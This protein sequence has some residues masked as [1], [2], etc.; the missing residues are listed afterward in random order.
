[1]GSRQLHPACPF[2]LSIRAFLKT[3]FAASCETPV[4]KLHWPLPPR[5]KLCRPKILDFEAEIFIN[6]L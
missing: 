2:C 1:M 3:A 4:T 5:G 6:C